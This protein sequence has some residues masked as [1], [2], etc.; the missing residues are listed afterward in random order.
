MLEQDALHPVLVEHDEDHENLRGG[1]HRDLEGAIK[2]RS[3]PLRAQRT[4]T[5]AVAHL[6]SCFI[7]LSSKTDTRLCAQPVD[8]LLLQSHP[9][10]FKRPG[11]R[12][13]VQSRSNSIYCYCLLIRI[14][15]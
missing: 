5:H 3:L 9:D 13:E 6:S 10:P 7:D 11:L 4:F 1:V 14:C 8:A 2:G 15:R 12:P